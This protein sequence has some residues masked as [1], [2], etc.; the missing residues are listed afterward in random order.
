MLVSI[1]IPTKNRRELLRETL[2]SV[3]AQTY[4]HWEAIVVDDGSTDGTEELVQAK[5]AT[6][7]R[8]RFV[9]REQKPQGASTCRN[10]GVS[11]A[12][13]KYVVFLDSDDLLAPTCLE[14]RIKVMEQNPK[15]DFAVFLTGVFHRVPGDSPHLWNNFTEEDDLDRFLR[16]DTPWHTSGPIWQKTSLARIGLWDER[17]L[18]WQDWEFHIRSIVAGLN[19]IKVT[20]CDSFWRLPRTD[21]MTKPAPSRRYIVSR[22]RLFK[23][24][25]PI[26]RFS[27]LWSERRRRIWANEYYHHAFC[28][29]NSYRLA[30]KIWVSG[31][32]VRIVGNYEFIVL[33]LI[34]MSIRIGQRIKGFYL[35]RYFPERQLN[36][37]LIFTRL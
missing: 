22:I 36:K 3:V 20:Q 23:R 16:Q 33:L 13:G 12:K 26:V 4:P 32:R 18:C 9:R 11:N 17:A 30:S 24:L 37:T 7:N 8:I 28:F 2:A 19:Y 10:I 29:S 5:A 35:R 6:Q 15:L 34:E 25:V 14:Q 27:S 1:V 31:Q 21:S